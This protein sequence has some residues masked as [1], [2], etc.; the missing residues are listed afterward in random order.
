MQPCII[1]TLLP[2]KTASPVVY[3]W[4]CVGLI[5][6]H[7]MIDVYIIQKMKIFQILSAKALACTTS[8]SD[9]TELFFSWCPVDWT[10]RQSQCGPLGDWCCPPTF[11]S[12]VVGCNRPDSN[13]ASGW[14]KGSF[15]EA[16]IMSFRSR[17]EQTALSRLRPSVCL[18]AEGEK[19]GTDIHPDRTAVKKLKL[20]HIDDNSMFKRR[21]TAFNK[22]K[23]LKLKQNLTPQVNRGS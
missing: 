14:Q 22:A 4:G 9:L 23:I 13:W 11:R 10:G 21:I 18:Q 12:G 6:L 17:G 20:L 15:K 1:V 16:S 5:A 2:N 3:V 8:S 19:I 7:C